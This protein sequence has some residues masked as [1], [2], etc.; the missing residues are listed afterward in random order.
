MNGVRVP[1]HFVIFQTIWTHMQ[2]KKQAGETREIPE[3]RILEK[4]Q[5]ENKK[6]NKTTKN[7]HN[8]PSTRTFRIRGNWEYERELVEAI[9]GAGIYTHGLITGDGERRCLYQK[10][11]VHYNMNRCNQNLNLKYSCLITPP[12]RHLKHSFEIPP[13]KVQSPFSPGLMRP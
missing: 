12:V 5:S 9:C 4:N 8:S 10:Y 7:T 1:S 11:V 3:R 6:V 2:R 13:H